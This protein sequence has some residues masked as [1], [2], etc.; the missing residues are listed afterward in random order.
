MWKIIP[1]LKVL[2]AQERTELSGLQEALKRVRKMGS[3]K[4][5]KD[6][7]DR[8]AVITGKSNLSWF[9]WTLI[10]LCGF[11]VLGWV[12]LPALESAKSFFGKTV[13]LRE[14]NA[15]EAQLKKQQKIHVNIGRLTS[16]N[17]LLTK[18]K[19]I[20]RCIIHGYEIILT[21]AKKNGDVIAPNTAGVGEA[22]LR[23]QCSET[24]DPNP[25]FLPPLR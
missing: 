20:N 5:G 4:E 18:E 17:E 24:N 11:A 22:Q 10:C 6:I 8:I 21:L 1:T 16:T 23:K 12:L 14:Y 19:T 25:L 9:Q 15:L 13:P 3:E 2:T 7:L